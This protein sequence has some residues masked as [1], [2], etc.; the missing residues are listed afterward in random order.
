MNVIRLGYVETAELVKIMNAASVY[1]SVAFAEGFGLPALEAIACGT[2]LVA[3]N[4][5]SLP[6][7]CGDYA[8]YCDPHDLSSIK[9]AIKK[10]LLQKPTPQRNFSWEETARQTTLIYNSILHK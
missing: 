4:T 3:S 8:T 6:E 7:I 9:T 5:H 10:T 1:C 2:P